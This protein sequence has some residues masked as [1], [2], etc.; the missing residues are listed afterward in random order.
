MRMCKHT[1]GELGGLPLL[2]LL[3]GSR[4]WG[5]S[6]DRL[7]TVALVQLAGRKDQQTKS[8]HR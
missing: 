8:V 7:S 6:P 1:P 5:K 2:R 3:L 4:L